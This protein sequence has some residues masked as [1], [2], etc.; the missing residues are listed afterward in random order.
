MSEDVFIEPGDAPAELRDT[1]AEIDHE[2]MR[3]LRRRHEAYHRVFVEGT[4]LKEDREIVMTDMAKFC[5]AFEITVR[6]P[7]WSLELLE[8]RRQAFL[9]IMEFSKLPV[10][11]LFR[12]Y[13]GG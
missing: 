10:D 3:L 5:R 13:H 9:R 4:P 11:V 12:R 8:G 1:R 7:Q 6:D 2:A